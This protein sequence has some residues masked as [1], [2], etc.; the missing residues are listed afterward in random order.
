MSFLPG[1]RCEPAYHSGPIESNVP[2]EAQ[3]WHW[4]AAARACFFIDP[5]WRNLETL[6]D[7]FGSEYVLRAQRWSYVEEM[8]L[9]PIGDIVD[10]YFLDG[11]FLRAV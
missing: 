6:C 5:A 4:I 7:F 3:T 9:G 10:A 1:P 2:A 11:P 8:K